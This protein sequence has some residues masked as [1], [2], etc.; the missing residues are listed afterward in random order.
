MSY[1]IRQPNGRYAIYREGTHLFL[2][3]N[4]T[5]EAIAATAG[6]HGRVVEGGLHFADTD[7]DAP[8]FAAVDGPHGSRRWRGALDVVRRVRGEAEA[9]S[10]RLL[11]ENPPPR[12]KVTVGYVVTAPNGYGGRRYMGVSQA[13]PFSANETWSPLQKEALRLTRK[14]ARAL[15]NAWTERLLAHTGVSIVRLWR[16]V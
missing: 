9:E 8:G 1:Y 14:Q 7:D 11:G 2:A 13:G 6:S 10:V 3:T 15:V 16:W 5:R 12:V 4:L